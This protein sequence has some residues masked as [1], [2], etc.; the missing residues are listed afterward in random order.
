LREPNPK[1][2][3]DELKEEVVEEEEGGYDVI[4]E[5]TLCEPDSGPAREFWR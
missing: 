5:E 1:Y 4:G 2:G 3:N